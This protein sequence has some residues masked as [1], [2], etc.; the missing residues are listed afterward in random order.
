MTAP[1]DHRETADSYN[2]EIFRRGSFRVIVCKDGIQWILQRRKAAIGMRAGTR[3]AALG[4]FQ[5]REALARLW[6]GKTGGHAPEIN[7]LPER[8]SRGSV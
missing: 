8:I 1:L 3:W 2:G 6:H 4:Y 5:T 7:A